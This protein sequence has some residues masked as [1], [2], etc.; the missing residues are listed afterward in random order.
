MVYDRPL[1]LWL[2][3]KSAIPC[4][5]TFGVSVRD[6]A[7]AGCDGKARFESPALAFKALSRARGSRARSRRSNRIADTRSMYRC[8]FCGGWHLG[9][10]PE[11]AVAR[12]GLADGWRG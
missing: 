2:V 10:E 11:H 3:N 6:H 12:L 5:G 7:L 8:R 1:L 4:A 9:N